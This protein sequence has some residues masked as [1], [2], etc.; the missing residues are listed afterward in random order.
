MPDVLGIL[1]MTEPDTQYPKFEQIFNF[2]D[3]GGH[4]TET[5]RQTRR[6]L[7]FRSAALTDATPGDLEVLIKELG[8][9]TLVD[10]RHREERD[11]FP[12]QQCWPRKLRTV[13][14]FESADDASVFPSLGDAYVNFL[15]RPHIGNRLVE[16]L[17]ILAEASTLPAVVF[18]GAGKDRTG[19]VAAAVLSSVGVGNEEIV[20]DYGNSEEHLDALYS[21]WSRNPASTIDEI[22]RTRAHVVGAPKRAMVQMLAALRQDYGS[23][24]AYLE[25]HGASPRLFQRLAS[26]LV[27]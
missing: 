19:M 10:L 11:L 25:S 21:F 2:R 17:S 16:A 8:V 20:E 23:M 12:M 6:D 3:L 15:K 18:C 22:R 7:L 9:R 5:G 4:V 26:V 1:E 14:I 27:G 13:P 24:Q